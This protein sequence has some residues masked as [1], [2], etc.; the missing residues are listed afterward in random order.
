MA[1]DSRTMADR[2]DLSVRS[3]WKLT[4]NMLF[5]CIR[6]FQ[7]FVAGLDGL[8]CEGKRILLVILKNKDMR[9]NMARDVI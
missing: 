4:H 2:R 3:N 6:I 8:F 1:K 9:N 5:P 7:D